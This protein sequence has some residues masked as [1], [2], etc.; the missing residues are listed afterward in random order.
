ML[1]HCV[2]QTLFVMLNKINLLIINRN[3]LLYKNATI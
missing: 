2:K 3:K 1:S